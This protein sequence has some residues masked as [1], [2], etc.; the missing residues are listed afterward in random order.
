MGFSIGMAARGANDLASGE[1]AD[2]TAPPLG[3]V[4]VTSERILRERGTTKGVGFPG[5][6]TVGTHR[7][8][9]NWIMSPPL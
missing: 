1:R 9:S 6:A 3:D 8:G 5:K 2:H 7:E 4:S